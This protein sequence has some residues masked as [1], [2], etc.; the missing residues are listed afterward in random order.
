MTNESHIQPTVLEKG[1]VY[2]HG[3]LD[4]AVHALTQVKEQFTIPTTD[5]PVLATMFERLRSIRAQIYLYL[6][7]AKVRLDLRREQIAS[8]TKQIENGA[9]RYSDLP[10]PPFPSK[11]FGPNKEVDFVRQKILDERARLLE[12]ER[13]LEDRFWS[14]IH[15]IKSEV[16]EALVLY[17]DLA[18]RIQVVAGC[19]I[20]MPS[21]TELFSFLD[22]PGPEEVVILSHPH[23]PS[24][25]P[26]E[27][28]P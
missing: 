19:P 6:D 20:P 26:G 3:V 10:S 11:S 12:A 25:P 13:K 15:E 7:T 18:G 2:S 9:G 5:D 24:T 23:D 17:I 16:A 1:A 28:L 27:R 4:H 21:L 14:D 8:I 22:S